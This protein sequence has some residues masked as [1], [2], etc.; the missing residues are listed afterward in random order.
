MPA[1]CG[2]ALGAAQQARMV[3]RLRRRL[4][5]QGGHGVLQIE[6]HISFVLVCGDHAYK[7][8]KALRTPFLDQST[9]AL[10]RQA[11]QEELRLNRRLAADLYVSV[12]PITGTAAAPGPTPGSR[13][14]WH[15]DWRRAGSASAMVTCT[16][17]T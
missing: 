5:A 16:W 8:K 7:I 12:V 9:L 15:G 17:A 6:T 4:A 11:C 14:R 10:R 2:E 13:R 3:R 1:P